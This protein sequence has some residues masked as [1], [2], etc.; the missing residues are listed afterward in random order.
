MPVT[1]T[2]PTDM[3]SGKCDEWIDMSCEK[4]NITLRDLHS[5]CSQVSQQLQMKQQMRSMWGGGELSDHDCL[6]VSWVPTIIERIEE[7]INKGEH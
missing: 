3:H 1:I 4:K 2:I 7:R 5:V 6:S